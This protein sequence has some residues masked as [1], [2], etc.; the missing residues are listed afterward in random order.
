MKHPPS[1]E[2][3]WPRLGNVYFLFYSLHILPAPFCL[4]G[5][6][7]GVLSRWA[8]GEDSPL[9]ASELDPFT[10]HVCPDWNTNHNKPVTYCGHETLTKRN[11]STQKRLTDGVSLCLTRCT[12]RLTATVWGGGEVLVVHLEQSLGYWQLL[13]RQ[14][15]MT[16]LEGQSLERV[17]GSPLEGGRGVLGQPGQ[18]QRRRG[19]WGLVL[20]EGSPTAW[21]GQKRRRLRL[22]GGC[23]DWRCKRLRRGGGLRAV[24]GVWMGAGSCESFN[25]KRKKVG[26]GF[27]RCD[28]EGD[29]LELPVVWSPSCSLMED[30]LVVRPPVAGGTG[31]LLFD[32]SVGM[33]RREG[34]KQSVDKT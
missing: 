31:Q 29:G 20:W 16:R 26:L 9:L 13:L 32:Q 5:P 14:Q 33:H 24:V 3:L 34:C 21:S 17:Q 22:D 30:E 8:P 28:S 7:R 4:N 18:D 23:W 15:H 19:R 2:T 12:F 25:W 11:R 6:L 1:E 27:L 10:L